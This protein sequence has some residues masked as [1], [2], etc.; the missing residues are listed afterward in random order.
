MSDSILIIDDSN[1]IQD[2]LSDILA[3]LK[4]E[5]TLTSTIEGAFKVLNEKKFDLIILDINLNGRNGGEI[6]KGLI[7]QKENPNHGTRVFILSGIINSVFI[8]KN[9]FRFAGIMIKPFEHDEFVSKVSEILQ[10]RE[11]GPDEIKIVECSLPFPMPELNKK[12]HSTLEQ[13]KKNPKLK[14]LFKSIKV[15]RSKDNYYQVHVGMLV[16]ISTAIS[17]AMEWSNDK[18]LE[19]FVYASY[20]HDMA[21]SDRPDLLRVHTT[22]DILMKGDQFSKIDI[23]LVT[24]HPNLAAD[25]VETYAEIPADVGI[26]I[27]QHHETATGNGFP[28]KI[29]GQK[30]TALS[31]IFLVAHDLVDYILVNTEWKMEKYLSGYQ[32]KFKG[33]H[34]N[35]VFQALSN[36]KTH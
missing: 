32:K 2:I 23:D 5:I 14:D 34:F 4:V 18:T 15:D 31:A 16:N 36:L 19:K 27:R 1:D 21:I 11:L 30:I 26:I 20:L 9:K 6:F 29:P 17:Q 24:N 7:E 25:K 10:P 13:V 33:A 8:E 28:N 35:K 12:V 3:P 22:A